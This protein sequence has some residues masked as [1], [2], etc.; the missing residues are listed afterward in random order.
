MSSSESIFG[1]VRRVYRESRKTHDIAWNVYVARPIAAVL[2]ALLR[3]TPLTPNQVTILGVVVFGAMAAPAL[4]MP[5]PVG[6]VVTALVIQLA[7]I[8]DC[9]D[10]QLARL[11]GMTS[12]VGAYFDFLIDEFKALFLVVI[13]AVRQWMVAGDDRWL[14]LGLYGAVAVS[15]ATSL[16]GFVRRKEYT[17]VEVKPGASAKQPE[18]P[19]NPVKLALWLVQRTASFLVHYPSW[20]VFVALADL[21]PAV[22]GVAWFLGLFLGVY[23]VYIARTGLGVVWKLGRPSFYRKDT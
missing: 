10:G 18:M 9:A 8:F 17:G 13:L 2:V 12:E 16:T 22:N 20:I 19:K 21:H 7:Y 6:F 4:L 14:F 15:V 1:E 23:T 3:R 5:T 11:K